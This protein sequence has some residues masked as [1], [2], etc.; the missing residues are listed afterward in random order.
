MV[1]PG[2]QTLVQAVFGGSLEE[3]Y[4]GWNQLQDHGCFPQACASQFAFGWVVVFGGALDAAFCY[5]Y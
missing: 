4:G 1:D 2:G 5:L 3:G